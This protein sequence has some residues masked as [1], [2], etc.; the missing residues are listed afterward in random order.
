M[1]L[2]A[3]APAIATFFALLPAIGAGGVMGLP[4][5]L[6]VMGALA[7]RPSLI[8]QVF[9][10]R[11]LAVLLLL[12]LTVWVCLTS[13]WSA[14]PG[15]AQAGK[16]AVLVPLGLMFAA[17]AGDQKDRQLTQAAGVAAFV[18]LAALMVI[19]VLWDLPLNRAANPQIPPHE[20]IRNVNRG[21]A[22][23]LA[24]TWATAA[25]LLV[26]GRS[27]AARA[28]L[29]ASLLLTLPLGLWANLVAFAV[30]LI[31]FAI[32]FGAPR[33]AIMSVSAGLAV[34]ML[35][36][37]F[38]TPLILANQ[39]LVDALPISW[40]VRAGIWEY[41][42]GRIL[43]QPW[44]GHGLDA[45]RAVTDRIEVRDLE[46]RAVSLHPH[47]ASLQIWFE[48]G[49]VGAILSAATLLGGGWAL[50]RAFERNRPAAAAAAASLAS[51]G[52]IANLSFGAWQEWWI[53]TL[54]VTAA[55]VGALAHRRA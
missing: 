13:L 50:A 4:V 25:S 37:P 7:I 28:L 14:H 17:A 47:S 19:E 36:A 11:P 10:N 46:L 44:L 23:V 8:A 49:A 53:A 6:C 5:V 29:A 35:A 39:R 12:A 16:L 27:N 34:W 15:H 45:S 55:L 20:V 30:G 41:V 52:I 22:L 48:T 54:F 43:E 31:V 1:R 32:A 21:A 51:L 18:V 33:L 9:E 38:L 40:A 42:C 3:S 26:H 24:I 2:T